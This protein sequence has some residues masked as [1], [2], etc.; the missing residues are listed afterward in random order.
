MKTFLHQGLRDSYPKDKLKDKVHECPNSQIIP[1]RLYQWLQKGLMLILIRMVV[2]ICWV[3][4]CQFSF[5]LKER[6]EETKLKCQQEGWTQ[7][8]VGLP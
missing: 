5:R 2:L 7:E 1:F 8:S 3:V 6:W 4:D